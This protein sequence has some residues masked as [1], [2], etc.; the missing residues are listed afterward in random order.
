MKTSN[1][2]FFEKN[3]STTGL[4]IS[5]KSQKHTLE[6]H[7]EN[8]LRIKSIETEISKQNLFKD[9]TIVPTKDATEQ[10][11][12]LAHSKKYIKQVIDQSKKN[13]TYTNEKKWEPYHTKYAFEAATE[14]AGSLIELTELVARGS[15]KNGFAAIRP[16]GHHALAEKGMGYCV[17]NNIAISAKSLLKNGLAKKILIVDIDAHHGNGI[18]E[19]FKNSEEVVY[20]SLHQKLMFPYTG[21]T[22]YKNISNLQLNFQEPEANHINLLK[23]NLSQ[24]LQKFTPDFI[25]VSAGYDAHWRD[26]MSNLGLSLK[27]LAEI[28]QYLVEIANQYSNGKIVFSLEG[29]YDLEVLS[30]GVTNTLK[31]LL[32]RNDFADPIGPVPQ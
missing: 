9:L 14:A 32:S 30:Y 28:S 8:H 22:N 27:G 12:E 5:S 10:D 11:L 23:K 16:P 7:P 6:G 31:A 17:F 24:I 29:G 21:D 18:E 25:I 15:L 3:N 4:V 13:Q 1:S 26:Y 2:G 20:L 19:I